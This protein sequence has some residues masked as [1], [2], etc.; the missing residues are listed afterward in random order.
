MAIENI[1][2]A[3]KQLKYLGIISLASMRNGE[4]TIFG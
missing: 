2:V 1:T 4:E 3:S